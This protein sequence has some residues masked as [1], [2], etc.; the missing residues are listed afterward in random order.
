MTSPTSNV[1]Q[2]T[3]MKNHSNTKQAFTLIE[4]L[5]VLAIIGVLA[6]LLFPAINGAM[7]TAKETKANTV[8]K[9]LASV[10][11]Q[12]YTEYGCWPIKNLTPGVIYRVDVLTVQLLS[13]SNLTV[14]AAP[15]G[16]YNG[17]PRR[18]G[19]F[20]FPTKDLNNFGQFPNLPVGSLVSATGTNF[21]FMLDTTYINSIPNPLPSPYNT[22]SPINKGVIV[23]TASPKRGI[24]SRNFYITSW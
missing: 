22:P 15:S 23:W 17:N 12:Y 13:G 20:D 7:L 2:G 4:I 5:T 6:A 10:F 8:V 24:S 21:F 11:Q 14:A 18:L 19:L 16:T 3:T 1:N 9:G